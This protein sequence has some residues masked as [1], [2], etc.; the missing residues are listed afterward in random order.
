VVNTGIGRAVKVVAGVLALTFAMV[1]GAEATSIQTGDQ[2]KIIGFDGGTLGAGPMKIDGPD[3]DTATDFVTFCLEID[4]FITFNTAYYVKL[5][6]VAKDGGAAGPSPDP[7]DTRTA[8]LYSNYLSNSLGAF[9]YT[10]D[11]NS[12]DALQLAIWRIE[13]EVY[14]DANGLYRRSDT[15]TQVANLTK[16]AKA[17]ALFNAATSNADGGFYNIQVMQL[18]GSPTF[19]QNKQDLL[20][21]VIP[22][23][24]AVST[25]GV[26]LLGLA[27]VG[28][29]R[30]RFQA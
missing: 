12:K 29:A 2:I 30:S 7:L 3:L 14:R 19:T 10:G 11:T 15:N 27:A 20:I 6:M 24:E 25:L 17:D 23:P 21:Q 8:Y 5:D 16:S 4:E 9:G 26:L 28:A 1:S 13:Q 18:W 22:V